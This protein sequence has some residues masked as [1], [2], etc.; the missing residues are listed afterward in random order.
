MNTPWRRDWLGV[1][2]VAFLGRLYPHSD[3]HGASLG[4]YTFT[5]I[6]LV[7]HEH[8]RVSEIGGIVNDELL[9]RRQRVGTITLP[10]YRSTP[11]LWCGTAPKP[12]ET[13]AFVTIPLLTMSR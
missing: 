10:W 1:W 8:A 4:G 2:R 6:R 9:T 7:R 3:S 5:L 12:Y 13:N 11:H